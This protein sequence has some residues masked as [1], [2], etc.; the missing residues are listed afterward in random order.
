MSSLVIVVPGAA[1]MP[2]TPPRSAQARMTSSGLHLLIGQS[3]RDPEWLMQTG[4]PAVLD[5]LERGAI[6]G[7]RDVDEHAQARSSAR[8]PAARSG[9]ARR[10]VVSRQPEPSALLSLYTTPSIRTPKP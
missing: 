9:S 5:R 3:S 2:M 4:D 7:V 1:S 10:R 8:P 6:A